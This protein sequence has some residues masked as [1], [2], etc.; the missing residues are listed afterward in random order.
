MRLSV[1][2]A[3]LFSAAVFAA[4]IQEVEFAEE[5]DNMGLEQFD[6]LD[7]LDTLDALDADL[8]VGGI[9]KGIGKGIANVGKKVVGAVVSK[10]PGL[11]KKGLGSL[12]S[13]ATEAVGNAATTATIKEWQGTGN[14]Q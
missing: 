1:I 13:G 4:P 9:L 10:A 7:T 12:A 8:K 2:V 3:V 14:A 5:A 11:I 6:A